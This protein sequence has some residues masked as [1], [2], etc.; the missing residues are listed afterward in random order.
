MQ[1]CAIFLRQRSTLFLE[2]GKEFLENVCNRKII[3]FSSTTKCFKN[4]FLS[5]Y[6]SSIRRSILLFFTYLY[7][8]PIYLCIHDPPEKF[9]LCLFP[10]A[11]SNASCLAN[12][13]CIIE[14]LR[15]LNSANW[16]IVV[17]VGRRRR[18]RNCSLAHISHMP[19]IQ[20]P[21]RCLAAA[22]AIEGTTNP[23]DYKTTQA[24]QQRAKLFS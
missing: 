2:Y 13:A 12:G 16:V 4:P 6:R 10:L 14:L 1:I 7:Y 23:A 15:D 18:I 8:Y 24:Q 17:L 3:C 22:S 9:A 21:I 11:D 5:L 20:L 19:G